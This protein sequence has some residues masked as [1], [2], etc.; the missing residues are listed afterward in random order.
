MQGL[1]GL[2]HISRHVGG[3]YLAAE[4]HAARARPDAHGIGTH[5]Q[6]PNRSR[7]PLGKVC[8]CWTCLR[9]PHPRQ[10]P[11]ASKY[12]A[13][14]R[15]RLS[16]ILGCV[17]QIGRDKTESWASLKQKCRGA[18][19]FRCFVGRVRGHIVEKVRMLYL[20]VFPVLNWC[21]ATRRWTQ[22]QMREARSMQLRMTRRALCFWPCVGEE[23]SAHFKRMVAWCEC[24]GVEATAKVPK[25]DSALV[26]SW[27]RWAGYVARVAKRDETRVLSHLL[28]GRVPCTAKHC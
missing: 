5:C 22:Q 21:S 1:R 19:H 26:T 27:W 25:W 3:R 6:A 24:V 8:V 11:D 10:C 12:A 20:A 18:Y 13:V 2:D 9:G 15:G 16:E 4:R 7:H 17:I 23:R 28:M 14:Q